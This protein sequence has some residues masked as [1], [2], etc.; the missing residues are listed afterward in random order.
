VKQLLFMRRFLLSSLFFLF[1]T[2]VYSQTISGSVKDSKGNPVPGANISI[3]DSYDGGMTDSLGRYSFSTGEKGEKFLQFTAIGYKPVEQK[4]TIGTGNLKADAILKEEITELKAV[5]IT[6]GSFEASDKKKTTVLN[7]IDIVTTASANADVTAAVKTLPGAQQVGESEGLFVRGGTAAETKIFI[8]GS[9]VNNFFYTSTPNIASRGRFSPFIFKGTIFSA[10]GYSA[11]YGQAL[12][13]ALILET[14][15]LPEQSSASLSTSFIGGGGGYQR[16]SKKKNASW[17][18][19]Y[20]YANLKLAFKLLDLKPEYFTVPEYHDGDANFRIKTSKT[21]ML[22]FYGY[23]S[24]NKVGLRN[25]SIDTP[26]FKDV[27][28]LNN[29]NIYHNIA[30]R[31]NLGNNWKLLLGLS[32]TNNLDNIRSSN[33]NDKNETV[34]VPGFE[35]KNFKLKAFG[36]YFNAKAVFEYRLRALSA[37]R[38][39]SEYNH[40]TDDIEYTTYNGVVYPGKLKENIQSLFGEADVYITN[41]LAARAGLRAEHSALLDKFNLAPRLS[42]AYKLGTASQASLAY[43]VFYQGPDKRY[44]PSATDLDFAKATHYI[45]QYQK[46]QGKT[47]LRAEVF[48]KKYNSLVKTGFVGG[49]EAAVSN[50]GYG[51]AKGFELFWRDRQTFKNFDYWISYS[52]LDT[53]RDFINFPKAIQPSFAAKHTASLVTKRFV[54]SLKT[55][56]NFSY[57]YA[58]GRPYYRIAYDNSNNK[59]SITDQGKTIDYNSLSFSVNYL[60]NVFKKGATKFNVFVFSVTNMLGSKQVYGYNYSYNGAR[61]EAIEP[62]TRTFI[63]L[64]AFFSF[65]ID[66]TQDAIDSKL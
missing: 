50:N 38:F 20:G 47:T 14:I 48:Y 53:E 10:G 44:L 55:Q 27:Y 12:S 19:G 28:R 51:E 59:F 40:S 43:G 58:S 22:K 54:T 17:G 4:I 46:L 23:F 24:S 60:P 35:Y 39:G 26:G 62:P 16:L 42:L 18:V 25:A 49:K 65:G 34:V 3:K 8:D 56:F 13:S 52:F 31:E 5:V 45:A 7:S 37:I 15:D 29:F 64:G 63:Y 21:G 41:S 30:Y 11:L 66:R 36:N 33:E 32:Y 2:V 6:A 9:L 1:S 61:K 57:T